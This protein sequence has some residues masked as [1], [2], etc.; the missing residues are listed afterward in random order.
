MYRKIMV[1]SLLALLV[2]GC[3]Q[4]M[5]ESSHPYA[6]YFYPVLETPKIYVYRDVIGGL[7]EQFHRVYCVQDAA[8]KHLIVERYASDGRIL[9]ALNFNVDSLDVQDHM[10]VNRDQKKTKAT[11]YKTTYFPWEKNSRTWFAS[12]FEGVM[13][14]T[15]ILREMKRSILKSSVRLEVL[16]ED[17]PCMLMVDSNRFTL[18]NPFLK[19]EKSLTE[20]SNSYYAEG[21][22]LVEWKGT[23]NKVHFKLEQ[24][25]SQETWLNV[26][27]R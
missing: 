24:I 9:E 15:L 2:S 5:K 16:G 26:M 7:E 6:Q 25:M 27:G 13:D 23:N 1:L 12:K 20:N 22:G 14:S 3:G 18:I 11:L 19:S 17:T 4:N 8:G 21:I 10:V